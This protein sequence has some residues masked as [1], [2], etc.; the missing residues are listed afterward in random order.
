MIKKILLLIIITIIP[1][2]VFSQETTTEGTITS[3]PANS[4]VDQGFYWD[5]AF[6]GR[7]N[8]FGACYRTRLYY[9]GALLRGRNSFWFAN[10]TYEIGM[11]QAIASFSRTSFFIFWQPI[12][13]VNFLVKVGYSKDF[14]KPALLTGA[15]DDYS[16]ALPPF[17]GLNPM[18]RE[19]IRADPDVLE[20]EFSPTFTF[21]GPAGF[22]MLAL[23]YNPTLI[24]M[25]TFG[26]SSDQYYFNNRENVVLK[27]QDIFW[28]HDVK[29]G[30]AIS[31]TGMSVAFT[32]IIEH[33]QSI[34]GIFRAGVF[35]SFSY[36]KASE[37]YPNLVPYFRGQVGTWIKDRYMTQYFAI[38][39]DTG[40]KVKF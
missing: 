29:L 17:T 6:R 26:L 38:Q 13:A 30:Y 11:E 5:N 7:W 2:A 8:A 33:V 24:Y 34:K 3:R 25:H 4:T 37:R 18:N 10:S 20:I 14:V 9:R 27:A 39:V 1:V 15:N 32:T 40:V 36:E 28:R 16:H 22:G 35:G 12:I 31:G 23:I 19:P 21:G